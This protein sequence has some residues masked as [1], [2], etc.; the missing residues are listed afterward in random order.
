MARFVQ[1]HQTDRLYIYH[2]SFKKRAYARRPGDD[3]LPF[4]PVTTGFASFFWLREIFR[5]LG[6]RHDMPAGKQKNSRKQKYG[7]GRISVDFAS[8]IEP[9]EILKSI[10]FVKKKMYNVIKHKYFGGA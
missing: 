8:S 1:I 5:S 2:A 6:S 4:G 7:K 9:G 3:R 10:D